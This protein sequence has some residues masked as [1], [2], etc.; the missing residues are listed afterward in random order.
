MKYVS[1][2]DDLLQIIIV[3]VYI[4]T[5]GYLPLNKSAGPATALEARRRSSPPPARL[6]IAP[7]STHTTMRRA[8]SACEQIAR[9]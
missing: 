5:P 1:V 7:R 8:T 9:A 4:S 3:I 2:E 6:L